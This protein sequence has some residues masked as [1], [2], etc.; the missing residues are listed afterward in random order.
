[1]CWAL[2]T[3]SAVFVSF[4]IYESRLPSKP[5][6][7]Y[8]R[9]CKFATIKA[10]RYPTTY[11]RGCDV[12]G[13]RFKIEDGIVYLGYNCEYQRVERRECKSI[14]STGSSDRKYC[15]H[16]QKSLDRLHR[17]HNLVV[18]GV[19]YLSEEKLGTY[20]HDWCRAL[21]YSHEGYTP[22]V[23]AQRIS[24]RRISVNRS[25]AIILRF[26]I[27][28]QRFFL[29]LFTNLQFVVEKHWIFEQWADLCKW[30]PGTWREET[31]CDGNRFEETWNLPKCVLS[32]RDRL[33]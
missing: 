1:M 6:H 15:E 22:V 27:R 29:P 20:F 32:E 18:T 16:H 8:L 13:N 26:A 5:W 7:G 9:T 17:Q 19:P 24:K 3:K 30:G 14:Q 4:F 28:S 31:S 10:N 12:H 25:S 23:S 21:G 11:T 33:G 2:R